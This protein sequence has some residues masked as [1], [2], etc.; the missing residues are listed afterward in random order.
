[1]RAWIFAATLLVGACATPLQ[2]S[3]PYASRLSQ[4]DVQQI[5][6]LVSKE[7]GLDHRLR[8][9]EAIHSDKVRIQTGGIKTVGWGYDD[10]TAYKRGGRWVI[11]SNS[12]EATAERTIITN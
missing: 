9:I 3:G 1:M 2:I 12:I 5:K 8:R 4:A 6:L 11:D 7:P 10:F